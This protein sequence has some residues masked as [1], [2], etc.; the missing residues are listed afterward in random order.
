MSCKKKGPTTTGFETATFLLVALPQPT[1]L[2]H[3]F[4]NAVLQIKSST[5]TLSLSSRAPHL[6]R[7]TETA[8]RQVHSDKE[9]TNGTQTAADVAH[10]KAYSFLSTL[11]S[12][13]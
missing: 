12:L 6:G 7:N 11:I 10:V 5:S 8:Y 3:A 9:F 4:H 1:V 2:P 13:T